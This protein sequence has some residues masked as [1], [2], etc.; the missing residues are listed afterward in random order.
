MTKL[1]LNPKF[2]KIVFDIL[3]TRPTAIAVFAFGSRVKGSAK[4]LSDLDLALKG[5]ISKAQLEVLRDH[6]EQ[7]DLPFKVDIVLWDEL[8]DGFKKH[9]QNDLVEIKPMNRLLILHDR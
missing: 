2:E 3:K 8:D 9:I 7:S 4:P 1:Q 6:F 5:K